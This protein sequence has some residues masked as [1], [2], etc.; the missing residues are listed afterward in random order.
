MLPINLQTVLVQHPTG[1]VFDIDG[2]LSPIAPTPEEARLYPGVVTLLEEARKRAYV[3]IMTGRAID[4]GARMVNVDGLTYIGNHGLE[5]SDGLPWLHPVHMTQEALVYVEP[6]KQLLDLVENGLRDIPGIIVQRKS[7]GGSIHYR[8]APDP[9]EA[10]QSI[11]SLLK[12]PSHKSGMHLSEGKQVVEV[13]APLAIN[14]GT[15]LRQY[16]RRLGLRGVLFAGDDQTDFDAVLEIARLREEGIAALSVVV[17]HTDTWP[18]LLKQ[19]DIVVQGVE[20]MVDLLKQV[21]ER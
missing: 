18:E 11:L 21:V 13:R 17:Q 19:A 15:A 4:D 14:K 6:G 2:T 7:V 16:A 1:L 5:W 3:A 20:G 12:E 9:K 8:L 10:R